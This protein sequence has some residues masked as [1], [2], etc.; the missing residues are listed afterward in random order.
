MLKILVIKVGE[1]AD[2]QRGNGDGASFQV[3]F[4]YKKSAYIG[5][6]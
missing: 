2:N 6:H 3:I 4:F 1:G 5:K